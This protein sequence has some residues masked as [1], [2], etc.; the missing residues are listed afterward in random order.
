MGYTECYTFILYYSIISYL[1]VA[2]QAGCS[3]HVS[4][5]R[6]SNL[7]AVQRPSFPG[8]CFPFHAGS[9]SHSRQHRFLRDVNPG[10]D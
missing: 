3:S 1:W 9:R 7:R 5:S 2:T 10:A 8:S 4:V 6:C